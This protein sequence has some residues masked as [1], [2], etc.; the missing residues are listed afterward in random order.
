[1]SPQP[2]DFVQVIN[3]EDDLVEWKWNGKPYR[4]QPGKPTMVPFELMTNMC[5]D[6]RANEKFQKIPIDG[7]DGEWMFI[8]P[9]G[10]EIARLRVRHG[11]AGDIVNR[12][13]DI[14]NIPKVQVRDLEGNEILTV[15]DDPEGKHTL[16]AISTVSQQEQTLQLIQ[17]QGRELKRLR[18]ELTA[19]SNQDLVNDS[20]RDDAEDVPS[21]D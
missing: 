3:T 20:T 12:L 6:P 9:R 13:D 15:I 8:A 11:G 5:G 18:E 17:D 4:L 7:E 1:M 21:D 2:G 14:P 16:Q 10:Y 19:L